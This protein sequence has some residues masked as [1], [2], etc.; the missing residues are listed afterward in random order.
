MERIIE[1]DYIF[2]FILSLS[3]N[4]QWCSSPDLHLHQSITSRS[5]WTL[6]RKSTACAWQMMASCSERNL[7]YEHTLQLLSLLLP[8]VTPFY[9]RSAFINSH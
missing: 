1:T 5:R 9:L 2:Y 6:W 4:K 8:S 3:Q 7:M